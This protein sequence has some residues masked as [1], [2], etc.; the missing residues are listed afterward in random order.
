MPKCEIG[1]TDTHIDRVVYEL[2]G[3]T[4][5]IDRTDGKTKKPPHGSGL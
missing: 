3:P 5:E 2:Y 1:A 4:D